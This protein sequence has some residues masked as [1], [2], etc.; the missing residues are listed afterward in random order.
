MD[1][2]MNGRNGWISKPHIFI[3]CLQTEV[4]LN[5]AHQELVYSTGDGT[6][7]NLGFYATEAYF[8]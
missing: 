8:Y 5:S 1:G 4:L 6:I 2:S 7:T 3:L